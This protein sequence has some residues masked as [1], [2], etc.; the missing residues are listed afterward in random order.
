MA[1]TA[2]SVPLP[3]KETVLSTY[4]SITAQNIL[5][6][7]GVKLTRLE[8]QDQLF[9]KGSLYREILRLIAPTLYNQMLIEQNDEIDYYCQKE[10]TDIAFA[11]QVELA[12]SDGA[13][14]LSPEQ[15]AQLQTLQYQQ[16]T[17]SSKLTE[18]KAKQAENNHKL[19]QLISQELKKWDLLN[20][21]CAKKISQTLRDQGVDISDD[22]EARLSARLKQSAESDLSEA[23]MKALKLKGTIHPI[24]KA[25]IT[26]LLEEVGK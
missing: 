19:D 10:L 5:K 16:E 24:N 2:I 15:T 20:E 3:A 13:R 8:L 25:V 11:N 14:S 23:T 9:S 1:K 18:L 6:K 7:Y 12:K 17:Q 4:L 26:T 22:F 21:D